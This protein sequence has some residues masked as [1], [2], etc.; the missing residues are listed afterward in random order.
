M[1]KLASKLNLTQV[2]RVCVTV[3]DTDRAIDFYVDTLGCRPGRERDG[4]MDVWYFGLQ[5][6]LQ[7]RPDQ[8]LTLEE[9]GARHFGATLGADEFAA[10]VERL[11]GEPDV[12]WLVPV[13]TDQD[14][15]DRSRRF[16]GGG[17]DRRT[18]G[19]AAVSLRC[20]PHYAS[21]HK[22]PGESLTCS[23]PTSASC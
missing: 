7:G 15:R 5:L 17:V 2:G 23:R 13:T 14:W 12:T 6:T 8:V 20:K 3:A 11:E 9:Q 22:Q 21:R 18:N 19:S 10:T 16:A 1:S 4:W